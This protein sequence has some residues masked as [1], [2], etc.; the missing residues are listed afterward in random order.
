MIP[1]NFYNW[2]KV[3]RNG[4]FVRVWKGGKNDSYYA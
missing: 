1:Y 4:R 2:T 3:C